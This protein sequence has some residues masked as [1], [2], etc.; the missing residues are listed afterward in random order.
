M[1]IRFRASSGTKRLRMRRPGVRACRRSFTGLA[2]RPLN[3][4]P[5]LL[6]FSNF[7]TDR[8]AAVSSYQGMTRF[9]AF[10][11]AGNVREW[12]SNAVGDHRWV[13]GGAWSDPDYMFGLGYDLPPFDRSPLKG[14]RLAAY[15][16][17]AVI[18]DAA[19]A[20]VDL[21]AG[22]RVFEPVSA[23]AY[24][25]LRDQLSYS[26]GSLNAEERHIDEATRDWTRERITLDTGYDDERI[27]LFLF[28]PTQ[29]QPPYQA[30][31]FSLA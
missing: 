27:T 14:V 24:A 17:E 19:F 13:L 8:P 20:A 2:P 7:G 9:G 18:P 21:R 22:D 28:L 31:V 12:C 10:D 29:G 25:L 5:P 16:D 4:H 3:W 1:R 26:S 11:M 23:E 30:V 15:P 6:P